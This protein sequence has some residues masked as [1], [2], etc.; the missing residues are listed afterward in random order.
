MR[1]VSARPLVGCCVALQS[2]SLPSLKS[3]VV[4]CG[5]SGAC[6]MSGMKYAASTFLAAPASAASGSPSLRRFIFGAPLA[7]SA[8]FAV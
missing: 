2:S 7:S 6:E 5:S 4:F 8:T 3:A 1:T